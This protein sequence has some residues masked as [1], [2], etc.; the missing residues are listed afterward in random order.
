MLKDANGKPVNAQIK[1]S[2]SSFP[3]SSLEMLTSRRARRTSPP[4]PSS[5]HSRS[6]STE[7]TTS[8]RREPKSPTA[9]QPSTSAQF[10]CDLVWY[11]RGLNEWWW[12]VW[13]AREYARRRSRG[14]EGGGAAGREEED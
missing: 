7:N 2:Q 8:H 13:Y 3:L 5:R 1:D 4:R 14:R 9:N 6:A 11:A 12:D 10:S